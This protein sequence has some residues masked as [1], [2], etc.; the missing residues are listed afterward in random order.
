MA[1]HLKDLYLSEDLADAHFVIVKDGEEI[2]YIP[3]HIL[4]LSSASPM[5][6]TQFHGSLKAE[7]NIVI[8]DSE[9]EPF[10]AMLEFIYTDKV[11]SLTM[12][13][14]FDVL[15]LA[16]KYLIKSLEKHTTDFMFENVSSTNVYEFLRGR[17]LFQDGFPDKFWQAVDPEG[18]SILKSEE[19]LELDLET[20]RQI[21]SR[22]T[23][24][25]KEKTVYDRLIAW[26]YEQHN[27]G[28]GN[29]NSLRSLLGDVFYQIRFTQMTAEE[30]ADGPS[31]DNHLTDQEKLDIFRWICGKKRKMLK[32]A[33]D[34]RA[35]ARTPTWPAVRTE[36]FSNSGFGE[37][38]NPPSVRRLVSRT[39]GFGNAGFHD[40]PSTSFSNSGFGLRPARA[41][42]CARRRVDRNSFGSIT[43]DL[44]LGR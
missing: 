30:F 28:N 21:V 9:P 11:S 16:H 23:L 6:R 24:K 37:F 10:K 22:N 33:T 40:Q 14:A 12:D 39:D 34:A 36:R 1:S 27:R 8:T 31:L 2:E 42:L 19:F 15:Y 7:E 29:V 13:I 41:T 26:A 44:P 5:F 25:V 35:P 38:G 18:E 4:L 3:A 17:L 20:V 43:C 32:F